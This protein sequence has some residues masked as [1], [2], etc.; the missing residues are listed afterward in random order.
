MSQQ[1]LGRLPEALERIPKH[2]LPGKLRRAV[3]NEI[4]KQGKPSRD[5]LLHQGTGADYR[6]LARST[7]SEQ[8][9]GGDHGFY[10]PL[11]ITYGGEMTTEANDFYKGVL[12]KIMKAPPDSSKS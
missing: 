1:E 10:D 4:V 5:P 11:D 2:K 3:N 7:G 9:I 6:P 12:D 8:V